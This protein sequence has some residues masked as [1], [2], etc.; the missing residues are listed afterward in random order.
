MNTALL[1]PA[2]DADTAIEDVQRAVDA[3]EAQHWALGSS[4]VVT[5]VI[6]RS[7]G[8]ALRVW[9]AGGDLAQL[10]EAEPAL[11]EIAREFGCSTI[12]IDGRKG[13]SRVLKGYTVQRV[14]LTRE[15]R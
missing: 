6:E 14:L 13:W 10:L 4:E 2:L 5:Q 12:E 3:S 7:G 1:T 9:L 11:D 8:L 15:V